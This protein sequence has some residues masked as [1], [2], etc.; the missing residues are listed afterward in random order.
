M[1]DLEIWPHSHVSGTCGAGY[2]P[3]HQ[4]Q[5]GHMSLSFR[6]AQYFSHGGSQV[7]VK[8]AEKVSPNVHIFQAASCLMFADIP[9][10]K[11]SHVGK[12]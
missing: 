4:R 12:L 3:R 11:I 5:L 10:A 9:L 1:V 7:S 2:Q 6:L 8:A